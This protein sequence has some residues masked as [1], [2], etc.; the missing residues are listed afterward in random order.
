VIGRTMQLA[1]NGS[2]GWGRSRR[3][4]VTAIELKRG[5][6]WQVEGVRELTQTDRRYAIVGL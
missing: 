1:L 6:R 3:G 2:Q 5:A 4:A